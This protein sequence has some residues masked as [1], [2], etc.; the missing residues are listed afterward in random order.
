MSREYSYFYG[1]ESDQYTFLRVPKILFRDPELRE[2]SI[3]AKILYGMMLDR[4]ALSQRNRWFDDQ[5]RAYICFTVEDVIE[6]LSCG[7]NKAIKSMQE[8]ERIGLIERKRQGLG[9]NNIIY[10]KK[11]M[12]DPLEEMVQKFKKQTSGENAPVSE[13]PKSNFKKSQNQTSGSLKSKLQEVY[14]R[15]PNNTNNNNTDINEIESYLIDG[16]ESADRDGGTR[17]DGKGCDEICMTDWDMYRELILENI[18]YEDLV[19]CHRRERETIDGIAD[20]ILETVVSDAET[21]LIA[22]S[23]YP[24]DLVKDKLLKLNSSHI[25][26]ALECLK[27]NTTK[28]KNIRKYLLAV[29]FNA[30]STINSYYQAEVNHDMPQLAVN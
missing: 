13:V 23:R 14:F 10:V 22:S 11:F 5:M 4:L 25:E 16:S 2:L 28:V 29:L 8:L 1:M 30:P 26:Y 15:D 17:C 7:R 3:E 20:L 12:P 19:R 18:D 27:K 6:E 9:R 24:K 21:I